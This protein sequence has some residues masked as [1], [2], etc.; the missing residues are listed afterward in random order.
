MP[1]VLDPLTS[2]S[3]P[4]GT[5]NVA[6]RTIT[7]NAQA[8]IDLLPY[9]ERHAPE[10][11]G[12]ISALSNEVDRL[13]AAVTSVLNNLF[14]QTAD[15]YLDFFEQLLGLSV[16]PPDKTLTQRRQSVLAFLQAIRNS[17]SGL[18]WEQN[19][20]RLIGTN[21][22]YTEYPG[23]EIE[24]LVPFQAALLAPT[25]VTPLTQAAGGTLGVGTY[26][27][28]VSATNTFGE[29]TPAEASIA[30]TVSG[31]EVTV[32]WGAVTNATAYR[33]YRGTVPN[34]TGGPSAPLLIADNITALTYTDLGAAPIDTT[35][36]P[37]G[38]NTTRS[39]FAYEIDVLLAQITPAHLNLVVGYAS[40]FLVDISQLGVEP[41]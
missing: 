10:I 27:Y 1:A 4:P 23:T 15:V 17:G 3:P 31:Q 29:T 2:Y 41:L 32:S 22:S 40:G 25:L 9:F 33:V 12:T 14:P 5:I 38:Q 26:Y 11:V 6:G 36:H 39:P 37:S 16:N 30:T 24:V 28:D 7:A 19:I 34:S 18:S 21:W 20:T 35:K 8:L 13:D